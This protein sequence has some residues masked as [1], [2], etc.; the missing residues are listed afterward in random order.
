M[1][2]AAPRLNVNGDTSIRPYRIGIRSVTRL[3]PAPPAGR[4]GPGGPWPVP[5]GRGPTV[6]SRA[7]PS[8]LR[9]STPPSSDAA[10]RWAGCQGACPRTQVVPAGA[11]L[12][13]RVL[14]AMLGC[15][16]PGLRQRSWVSPGAAEL[17]RRRWRRSAAFYEFLI[18]RVEKA[19]FRQTRYR[20]IRSRP[21][22]RRLGAQE[23]AEMRHGE[24]DQAPLG[25]VDEPLFDQPIPGR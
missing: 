9:R 5:T 1:I 12:A 17:P 4:P 10:T 13:G 25:A 24:R 23:P 22:L 11:V 8:C 21:F 19:I 6:A 3:S 20:R 2:S 15:Q 7:G 14:V 16:L 18:S